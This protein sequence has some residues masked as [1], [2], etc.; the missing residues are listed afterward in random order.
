MSSPRSVS[1]GLGVAEGAGLLS[2]LLRASL[3]ESR[4]GTGGLDDPRGLRSPG[5][6]QNTSSMNT[7]YCEDHLVYS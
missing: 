1:D 5:S 4:S 7:C 6:L 3:W 2:G